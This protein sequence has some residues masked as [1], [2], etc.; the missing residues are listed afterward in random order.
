V[1]REI[2]M[3][4]IRAA[5]RQAETVALGALD[6]VLASRL[7][8]EALDRVLASDLARGALGRALEG[9]L[10]E[11]LA[12][13]VVRYAVVERLADV[14]GEDPELERIVARAVDSAAMERMVVRVLES[15]LV[16]EAVRRLLEGE[17]LWLVVDEIAQS[18]AVTEA[19]ARQSV[20]FAD[21]VAGQVRDRSRS[22]D[23]RLERAAKR[24][25]R[26]GSAT[27]PDA[28]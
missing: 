5:G 10:V 26:R 15:K 4:P 17:E 13:D 7:T 22:A 6:A 14:I 12:R 27:G 20:S 8:A 3:A 28:P 23:A 11:A 18:P 16:D 19:I 25:L 9:P 21:Q 1:I 2:V 24:V